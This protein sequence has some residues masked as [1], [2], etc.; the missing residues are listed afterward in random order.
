[1]SLLKIASVPAA[2]VSPQSAVTEAVQRMN[3][4]RGWR[5]GRDR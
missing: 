4:K 1:M 2:T 3:D 5:G